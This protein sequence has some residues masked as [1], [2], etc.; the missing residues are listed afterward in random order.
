MDKED[1]KA[2]KIIMIFFVGVIF[3]FIPWRDLALKNHARTCGFVYG[4]QVFKGARYIFFSYKTSSKEWLTSHQHISDFKIKNVDSL[5]KM[6]CLQTIY[7]TRFNST[8]EI[9][10]E[11]VIER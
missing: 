6:K 4:Q 10:D 2:V 7:S 9:I 3:L 5:K 1:K 11:R 8:A